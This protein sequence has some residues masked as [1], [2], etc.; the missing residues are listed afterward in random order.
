M[1]DR[2]PS[3]SRIVS[4]LRV[5]VSRFQRVRVPY[6]SMRPLI[7]TFVATDSVV[8]NTPS[9]V[10]VRLNYVSRLSISLNL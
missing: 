10:P 5:F 8:G 7:A 9:A 3:D 1:D 2:S 6:S 4:A